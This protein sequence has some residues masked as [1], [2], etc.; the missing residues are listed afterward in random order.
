MDNLPSLEKLVGQEV[1]GKIDA[2]D[3]NKSNCRKAAVYRECGD[4]D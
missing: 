3:D 4:M 2:I 1:V